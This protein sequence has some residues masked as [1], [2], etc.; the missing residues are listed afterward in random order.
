VKPDVIYLDGLQL[1][2]HGTGLA[3]VTAE[4]VRALAA[5]EAK[6]RVALIL[7]RGV[8]LASYELS[9]DA[10]EIIEVV[11]PEIR[12]DYL[13]R[14]VWGWRVTAALKRRAPGGRL[15]IPYLYNYGRLRENVVLVPDLISRLVPND[16]VN[17]TRP[18]WSM[19]GRWPIRRF[20]SRYEEWKVTR[21][22]RIVVY[23]DFV[24]RHAADELHIPSER[25]TNIRLAAPHWITR[26]DAATATLPSAIASVLP[27]KFVFYVG[28]FAHHK[29][30]P[31]L[32]R[33]CERLHQLDS[34]FRCLFAGLGEL[35]R[36]ASAALRAAAI[37]LAKLR[38]EEL[39]A[40]YYRCQFAVFP[41]RS[42]GFGLPVIEAAACGRVCL[43]GDNSSLVEIQPNPRYRIAATDEDAWVDRILHFWQ[44]PEEAAAAGRECRALASGDEWQRAAQT[45]HEILTA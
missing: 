41:S 30:V 34:T 14:A 31:M 16:G 35:P 32:L 7:P 33:V 36:G 19:R 21:A 3:L 39:A 22:G 29:N 17:G 28:G 45:L 20:V 15:F 1:L 8:S 12:P 26:A 44:N 13:F 18:R 43:C 11:A 23:S 2:F 27:E 5:L 37:P 9:E 6:P 25:F 10:F 4:L 40:L 38:H 42:E 24:R